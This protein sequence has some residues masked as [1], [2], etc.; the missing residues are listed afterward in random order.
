LG[1]VNRL[2]TIAFVAGPILGFAACGVAWKPDERTSFTGFPMPI[3]VEVQLADGRTDCGSGP[4]GYVLNP[5]A[6]TLA[7]LVVGSTILGI[8]AAI[9][10][11]GKSSTRATV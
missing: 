3:G 4:L 6:F 1:A 11:R 9:R 5:I 8:R 10:S 2:V 7:I